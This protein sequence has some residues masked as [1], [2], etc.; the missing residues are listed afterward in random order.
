MNI[1]NAPDM[2]YNAILITYQRLKPQSLMSVTCLKQVTMVL[3]ATTVG[4]MYDM[5]FE[6]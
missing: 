3:D 1:S 5:G 2:S 6:I 4:V